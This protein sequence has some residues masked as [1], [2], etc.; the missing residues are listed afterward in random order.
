MVV[1]MALQK[2]KD[3]SKT[4]LGLSS[5]INLPVFDQPGRE[6][7]PSKMSWEDAVDS[8]AALREHYMR[9]F[10]SPEERLRRKN[11]EQFRLP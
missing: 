9:N 5:D 3:S 10:D 7:W 8:F 11:P 4:E 1:K 6:Y 2:L